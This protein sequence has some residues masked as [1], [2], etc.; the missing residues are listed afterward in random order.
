MCCKRERNAT[1]RTLGCHDNNQRRWRRGLRLRLRVRRRRGGVRLR[2]LRR[3]A[4]GL[5]L[6]LRRGGLRLSARFFREGLLVR[7]RRDGLRL[8]LDFRRDRERDGDRERDARLPSLDR[9][10]SRG[11]LLRMRGDLLRALV[12]SAFV[13]VF[14]ITDDCAGVPVV[15][16]CGAASVVAVVEVCAAVVVDLVSAGVSSAKKS[17]LDTSTSSSSSSSSS[18]FLVAESLAGPSSAKLN[19]SYLE[20]SPSSSSSSSI[21]GG[22][23]GCPSSAWAGTS[24]TPT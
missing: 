1:V 11:E 16:G 12:S 17:Y 23:D 3:R 10:R 18:R 24:G 21:S 14:S 19:R 20:V 6:R 13:T 5:R 4:D 2:D 9:R 8:R 7:C 15:S 22:T